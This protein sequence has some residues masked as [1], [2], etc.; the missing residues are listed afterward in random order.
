MLV[1]KKYLNFFC[2]K[3]F[4]CLSN[5]STVR[6]FLQR[7]KFFCQPLFYCYVLKQATWHR[8]SECTR[9]PPR[10]V[11]TWEWRFLSDKTNLPTAVRLVMQE[12]SVRSSEDD[13]GMPSI[14]DMNDSLGILFSKI[15]YFQGKPEK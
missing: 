13:F 1:T 10:Q 12:N 6:Q 3:F 2:V 14:L 15:H 7:L 11:R 9:T 8:R 5:I 4:V